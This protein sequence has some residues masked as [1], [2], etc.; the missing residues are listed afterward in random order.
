MIGCITQ[1]TYRMKGIAHLTVKF[2]FTANVF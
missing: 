1:L 2:N